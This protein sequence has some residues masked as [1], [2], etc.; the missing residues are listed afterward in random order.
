MR[1]LHVGTVLV[2]SFATLA[3]MVDATWHCDHGRAM[4]ALLVGTILLIAADFTFFVV[5]LRGGK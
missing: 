5:R 2:I 4:G 3:C 1:Y